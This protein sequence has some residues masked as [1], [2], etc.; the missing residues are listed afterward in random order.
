MKNSSRVAGISIICWFGLGI[1]SA[2]AA[3][4]TSFEIESNSNSASNINEI[5]EHDIDDFHS[6]TVPAEVNDT[7]D[8]SGIS[9]AKLPKHDESIIT[10]E[11][12][13]SENTVLA[14]VATSSPVAFTKVTQAPP[15]GS[16]S[17]DAI[18]TRNEFTDN[19]SNAENSARAQELELYAVLLVCLGLL[20]LTARR[21]RD[22]T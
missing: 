14:T 20:G 2:N 9:S 5:V 7:S 6:L 12:I 15:T 18:G 11:L 1:L 13:D 3:T 8:A 17:L 21:R 16:A 19:A 22:V 10:T 4:I